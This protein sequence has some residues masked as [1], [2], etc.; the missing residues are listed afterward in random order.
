MAAARSIV[1][2]YHDDRL[3]ESKE[4][5]FIPTNQLTKKQ[6]FLSNPTNKQFLLNEVKPAIFKWISF[7]FKKWMNL[8]FKKGLYYIG[9]IFFVILSQALEVQKHVKLRHF[10]AYS[11]FQIDGAGRKTGI[12][13]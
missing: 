3:W 4:A 11:D 7:F 6:F 2:W 10:F 13:F 1:P 12:L 8:R 9:D 5:P